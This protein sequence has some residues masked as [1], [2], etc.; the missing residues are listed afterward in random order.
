MTPPKGRHAVPKNSA[1]QGGGLLVQT[2]NVDLGALPQP[3]L[4]MTATWATATLHEGVVRLIFA[5][6]PPPL[7]HD[8][9]LRFSAGLDVSISLDKV[10][11]FLGKSDLIGYYQTMKEYIN[12]QGH[13]ERL[14]SLAEA[15]HIPQERTVY[16]TASFIMTAI[17]GRQGEFRFFNLKPYSY[18]QF[19]KG[20]KLNVQAIQSVVGILLSSE[21]MCGILSELFKI[22]EPFSGMSAEG[23]RHE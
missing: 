10:I 5:Q 11:D 15:S 2:V 16:Q 4:Y 18:H 13:Q 12:L 23:S 7:S 8:A 22:V 1:N 3:E 9:P 21:Y 14:G 17:E 6:G 19:S 20:H